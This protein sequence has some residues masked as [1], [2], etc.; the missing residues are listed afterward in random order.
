MNSSLLRR[1][2]TTKSAFSRDLEGLGSRDNHFRS[3]IA[4]LGVIYAAAQA[5]RPKQYTAYDCFD[6]N[7]PYGKIPIKKEQERE[8]KN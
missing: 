6:K 8:K 5:E 1:L 2:T 4:P 3:G 7:G